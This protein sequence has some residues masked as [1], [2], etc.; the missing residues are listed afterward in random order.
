MSCYPQTIQ[1]PMSDVIELGNEF[2]IRARSSLVDIQT[3]VLMRGDLFGVFDRNGDLRALGAGGHG[4]FYNESRHLSKS[5]LRLASGSLSLLSST[6][7]QDNPRLII[8]LTNPQLQL[9]DGRTLPRHTVHLQRIKFL[10]ENL[11]E[12]EV[13]IR[14]YGQLSVSL[15]LILELEADFADIFEIR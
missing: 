2:Y 4:L 7:T 10:R 1:P 5:V 8:D 11:C 9:P 3:R 12:E 15:E 14:N 6:V 13:R